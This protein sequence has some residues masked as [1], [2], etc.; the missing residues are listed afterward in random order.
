MELVNIKR[1][2]I[3]RIERKNLG[4]NKIIIKISSFFK[5]KFY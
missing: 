2:N 4:I 1:F 3:S 5:R